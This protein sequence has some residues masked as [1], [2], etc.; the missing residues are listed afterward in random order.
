MKLN[1]KGFTLVELLAVI[2][3]LLAISVIAVSSISAAIER[4]KAKQNNAKIEIILSHAKLYYDENK[5]TESDGK[6]SLGDLDLSDSELE[7][8][9]GDIFGGIVCYDVGGKNFRYE[10]DGSC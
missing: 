2:V 5:N 6:I 10:A 8:A 1:K 3:I 7:D 9:N 4:N